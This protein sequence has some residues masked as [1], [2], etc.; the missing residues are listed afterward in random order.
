MAQDLAVFVWY[1]STCVIPRVDEI[2]CAT[3]WFMPHFVNVPTV[4][5]LSGI[6]VILLKFCLVIVEGVRGA[7]SS[8]LVGNIYSYVRFLRKENWTGLSC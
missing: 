8:L 4:R 7:G 2:R 5:L 6:F 3:F 1:K